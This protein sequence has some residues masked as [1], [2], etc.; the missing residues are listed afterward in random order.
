MPLNL[1]ERQ[2]FRTREEMVADTL[3]DAILD[4]ELAPGEKLDQSDL[5]DSLRV[6]RTPVRSALQMLAKEG[7]V[8]V[9]PHRGAVVAQLSAEEVEEL[10]FIRGVLEGAAASLAASQL[11]DGHVDE[12]KTLLEQMAAAD[13]RDQWMELNTRFHVTLYRIAAGPRLLSMIRRLQ[14]LARP[15]S[16]EHVGTAE[17]REAAGRLHKR[18]LEACVSGNPKLA[19]TA[20]KRHLKAVAEDLVSQLERRRES[21]DEDTSI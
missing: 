18:I 16:R 19:E 5:A 1:D 2:R 20:T 13:G 12:L 8:Q 17:H 14:R 21:D 3:R 9:T 6:S 10:Y 4:G 15:Y 11:D 7:F